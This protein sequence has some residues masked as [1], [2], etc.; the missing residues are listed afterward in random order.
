MQLARILFVTALLLLSCSPSI[1]GQ[2]VRTD[3]KLADVR[4]RDVCI[5]ADEKTVTPAAKA[6]PDWLRFF[7]SQS[8]FG[9]WKGV[10]PTIPLG[11][12]LELA[13]AEIPYTLGWG[14]FLCLEHRTG[15]QA[16]SHP[17][18]TFSPMSFMIA[19]SICS[20]S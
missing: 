1:L 6:L 3:V 15:N 5:L 2:T 8:R 13:L 17:S 4:M 12:G 19:K 14:F 20:M 11:I 18:P 9:L 10:V 16:I 7:V